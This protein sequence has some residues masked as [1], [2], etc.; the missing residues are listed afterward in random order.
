[1]RYGHARRHLVG[2]GLAVVRR[3]ALDDVADVDLVARVAHRGD[4]L[5]E[6]LA[7]LADERLALRVL[8]GARAL[9]D[10]AELGERVAAREHGLASASRQSTHARRRGRSTSAASAVSGERG[11][12]SGERRVGAVAARHRRA[13]AERGAARAA[14]AL[15]CAGEAR[16]G[17]RD[18]EAGAAAALALGRS[19]ASAA[20]TLGARAASGGEA[21]S[22][23]GDASCRAATE[24][25][26]R[27][28]GDD[29]R[30][31]AR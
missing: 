29:R 17:A 6:Q 10:E 30:A 23:P 9:A 4:H 22:G 2:L 5:V 20:R 25:R 7:G 11:A 27:E 16:L 31:R 14:A 28:R 15:R 1:M 8:V 13:G 26:A 19:A 24:A 3:A 12:R 21:G 18:S